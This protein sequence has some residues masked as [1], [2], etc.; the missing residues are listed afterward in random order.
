MLIHCEEYEHFL[1]ENGLDSERKWFITSFATSF[2]FPFPSF[3]RGKRKRA[4]NNQL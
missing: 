4:R 3:F 1:G 2:S